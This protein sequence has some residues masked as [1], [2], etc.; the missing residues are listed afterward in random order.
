MF[1]AYYFGGLNIGKYPISP[2]PVCGGKLNVCLPQ[3]HNQHYALVPPLPQHS[4]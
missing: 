1:V 2:S 3:G 4:A